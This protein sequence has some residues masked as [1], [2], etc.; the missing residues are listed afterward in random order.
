MMD[1]VSCSRSRNA[2]R[3]TTKKGRRGSGDDGHRDTDRHGSKRGNAYTTN[4]SHTCY[5]FCTVLVAV[6]MQQRRVEKIKRDRQ[7]VAQGA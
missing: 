1:R 4:H 2:K 3:R 5:E 7:M 6:E